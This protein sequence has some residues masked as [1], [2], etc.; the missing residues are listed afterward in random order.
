MASASGIVNHVGEK[1]RSDVAA[2]AAIPAIVAGRMIV[3]FHGQLRATVGQV[4]NAD[5][6]STLLDDVIDATPRHR[7]QIFAVG[8]AG[9][10]LNR[11][12]HTHVAFGLRKPRRNLR[13]VNRPVLAE[14]V[15]IG[16]LEID[17]AEARGG[18]SPEIGLAAGRLAALP[19][20]IRARSIRIR[21]VVLEQISSLAVFRLFDRVRF[22]MR[23]TL[24]P[25]GIAVAAIF[26]VV[27]LP[28]QA[29]VLLRDLCAV[30]S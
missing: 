16:G 14:P 20:P 21:D 9:P 4:R 1:K 10:V 12:G 26:Q 13:I 18:P 8:I 11:A 22:L 2:A 29:V 23:L 15:E 6:F 3:V 27:N 24:E 19:V 28:M 7:R 25:Q 5:F 30:R 17:V